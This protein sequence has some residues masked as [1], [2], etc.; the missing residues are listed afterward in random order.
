MRR[1][2]G[3][4]PRRW[5]KVA[6]V[7][8][9]VLA[10]IVWGYVAWRVAVAEATA[11]ALRNAD[12]V[13]EYTLRLI[14]TQRILLDAADAYFAEIP[15][16]DLGARRYHDF[17]ASIEASQTFTFG[18]AYI[19]PDG[20]FV[21]S[22]RSFRP[23]GVV[24][25]REYVAR[26]RA[27]DE[28]FIDRFRLRPGNEDA[29]VITQRRKGEPYSG[30]FAAS[31]DVSAVTEFL[32]RITA[33][34]E[35]ASASLFRE[36]GKLL[37]RNFPSEP[38]MLSP[39]A[40]IYR[41]ILT[42]DRGTFEAKALTDGV[43]RIYGYSRVGDLPLFANFGMS[44]QTLFAGWV[45]GFGIN[46]AF[47]L[48][49]AAVGLAALTQAERRF[50]AERARLETDFDRKLL[51]EAR[52]TAAMKETMLRELSHRTKNNLQSVQAL[53][54]MRAHRGNA[55]DA[56]ELAQRVAAISDIH[57]LLYASGDHVHIDLKDFLERVARNE[58]LV[59]PERGIRL[60]HDLQ[61]FPLEVQRATPLALIVVELV[62]NAV[63]HAFRGRQEGLIRLRLRRA[64]GAALLEVSDDGVG[65]PQA[66][67]RDSGLRLVRGLVGQLGGDLEIRRNGG[68]SYL[69]RVPAMVARAE[70]QEAVAT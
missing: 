40:P 24:A 38:M 55:A 54:R 16:D 67:E 56:E 5:V 66:T 64:N 28:F 22:S 12:L 37:V 6:I 20:R 36:D 30:L 63:K 62:T 4:R 59:P 26:H 19:G 65:L 29:L 51:E 10:A 43:T 23:D 1:T 32:R 11:T 9:P 50:A 27:G 57:D 58:S 3:L 21:T 17:L 53:I 14:Q 49:V 69:I 45:V 47:L 52:A 15:G 33:G 13:R 60:E 31:V 42:A 35:G 48:T 8:A 2:D 41:A 70:P 7:V 44:T 34:D 18:L 46:A 68:T 39:E 61:S 25:D